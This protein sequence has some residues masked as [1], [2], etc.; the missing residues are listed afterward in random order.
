VELAILSGEENESNFE[1]ILV[2]STHVLFLVSMDLPLHDM[3]KIP[4]VD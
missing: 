4:L 2:I 3:E 1:K